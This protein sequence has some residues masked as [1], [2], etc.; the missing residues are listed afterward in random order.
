MITLAIIAI[1]VIAGIADA[2]VQ[3]HA[4]HPGV[5]PWRTN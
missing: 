5:E 3:R 4:A 2:A 1:I